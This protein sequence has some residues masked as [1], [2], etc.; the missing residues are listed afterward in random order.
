MDEREEWLT[1]LRVMRLSWP[2]RCPRT[3][4]PD[5]TA[6]LREGFWP[7]DM[8]DRWVIWLDQ[9]LLRVW[10]SWTG[11][12]IYEAEL[13]T[14]EAGAAHCQVLRV[15]DDTDMYARSN[16]ESV[17]IDRFEGVLTLLLGRKK[18]AAA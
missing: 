4:S 3:F 2:I 8:D 14:D 17:E 18:E 7:R 12:C 9:G 15:C 6:L 10:R 11:E 13:T 1:R 5:E 16:Q